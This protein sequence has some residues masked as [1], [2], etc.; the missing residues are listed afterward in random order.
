MRTRIQSFLGVLL[1]TW[2]PLHALGCGQPAVDVAGDAPDDQA[3]EA[4]TLKDSTPLGR[5]P[6][7]LPT[8]LP[9][10]LAHGFMGSST[11]LWSFHLVAAALRADGHIVHEAEVPPF[12]SP[13][14]R[15]DW[16][17]RHVDAAL[18]EAA[19]SAGSAAPTQVNIVAHSMGGLD[20]RVLAAR[21]GYTEKIASITTISTPHGG[22]LV[23][24]VALTA[25]GGTRSSRLAELVDDV[26]DKAANALFGLLGGRPSTLLDETNLRQTLAALAVSGSQK[27]NAEHP[28][29][30]SIYYQTW[31][32][33]SSVTGSYSEIVKNVCAGAPMLMH[34][35]TMDSMSVLLWASAPVVGWNGLL[36]KLRPNDGVATV[37]SARGIGGFECAPGIAENALGCFHFQGCFPADH[38]GEVGQPKHAGADPA[39][40]FDHIRFY[41]NLAFD[42]A[43]KGY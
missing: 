28:N 21:P 1:A 20:A 2:L 9:I 6:S 17:G 19:G 32:G 29:L 22:S 40:G 16:L 27:F 12:A 13:E 37:E 7:G 24:D 30:D 23:A 25:L 10:V 14:T 15:A 26:A 5:D 8:A 3:M 18:F 34:P 41:R 36:H 39:T 31:A 38:L 35:Q 11:N 42:L 43:A 33:V 4:V